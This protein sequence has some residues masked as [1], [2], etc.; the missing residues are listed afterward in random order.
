MGIFEKGWEKPSPIQEASIP[1]ALS[2][3]DILAR[4]KNGTGKTGAYSIPVLEQV[5]KKY[6][7]GEKIFQ[8]W[9]I[10]FNLCT[11]CQVD[12]RKD[13]IQALVI[14]PTRE[15]ALQTSQICIELAKH[16]DIKVMVTTGGTNLRDD[17]MRIYQKGKIQKK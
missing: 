11:I 10:I 16:M 15:L 4:A 14:V 2:G 13:V 3:K 12:P 6:Q 9:N 7:L 1:I 8:N 17:I 5:R